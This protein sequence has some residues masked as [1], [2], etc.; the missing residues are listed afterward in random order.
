LVFVISYCVAKC[1]GTTA[2][3]HSWWN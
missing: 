1:L 2:T 3:N